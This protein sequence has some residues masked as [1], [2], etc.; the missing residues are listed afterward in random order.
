LIGDSC[1]EAIQF[2]SA[3]IHMQ[4][5]LDLVCCQDVNY[6]NWT[7]YLSRCHAN[8]LNWVLVSMPHAGVSSWQMITIYWLKI[9]HHIKKKKNYIQEFSL[10]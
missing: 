6:I 5:S 4:I 2:H 1:Q 8:P 3:V 10:T 9:A 7:V